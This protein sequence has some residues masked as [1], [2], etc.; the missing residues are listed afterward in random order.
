[1]KCLFIKVGDVLKTQSYRFCCQQHVIK[2][3]FQSTTSSLYYNALKRS[4][5]M[6]FCKENVMDRYI[7]T[8]KKLAVVKWVLHLHLQFLLETNFSIDT[9]LANR[10]LSQTRARCENMFCFYYFFLFTF[11][12]KCRNWIPRNIFLFGPFLFSFVQ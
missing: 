11:L 4:T 3:E 2:F 12:S 1:M 10:R 5:K 6:Y 8:K 7:S 9:T